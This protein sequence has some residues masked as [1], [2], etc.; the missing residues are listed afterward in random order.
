[1]EYRI[2]Y[3]RERKGEAPLICVQSFRRGSVPIAFVCLLACAEQAA[4]GEQLLSWLEQLPWNERKWNPQKFFCQAVVS[5]EERL[6][7]Q[8]AERTQQALLF[9]LGKNIYL[10]QNTE[11]C[12]LIQRCIGKGTA[13]PLPLRF[14][15]EM[16]P[17]TCLV[18]ADRTYLEGREE[19]IGETLCHRR[20][21]R[22]ESWQRR[23]EE[24]SSGQGAGVA[25]LLLEDG[26]E[27]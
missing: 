27:A 15:G 13:K 1:M 21:E 17:G 5:L 8:P 18:L 23:L 16:E 24:L 11:K 26:D 4:Y 2:V 25:F 12:F 6:E 19:F 7:H 14:Q 10:H 9:A 3:Y 20:F 22:K